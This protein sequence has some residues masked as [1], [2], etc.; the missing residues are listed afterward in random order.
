[1]DVELLTVTPNAERIIERA[2]R[3]CYQSADRMD[4]PGQ[5]NLLKRLLE[6]G[7]ESPFEHAYATFRIKGCSRAMTHQLVRHR[8]MSVS[9]KSQR[10]VSEKGF[11]YVIPPKLKGDDIAEFRADME[12]IREMY[13]KWRKRGLANED[14]RFVLPNACASEIV[15][16][17]NFREFRH[18]FLMRCNR[19]AQWE[20][21]EACEQMLESL[22]TIA[23]RVFGDL[24]KQV[25]GAKALN[26][27]RK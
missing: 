1:M 11:E 26:E 21:R 8:L 16:S 5:G 17:A 15:I 22:Y 27:K 24:K 9:Q 25:A 4:L 12:R 2:A 18:I 10:Y 20:I 3:T 7:H 13:I 23:P 14:A 6:L 19:H